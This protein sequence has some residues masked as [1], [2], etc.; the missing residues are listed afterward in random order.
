VELAIHGQQRRLHNVILPIRDGDEAFGILGVNVDV[1]EQKRAEEALRQSE[2]RYRALAESTHDII[3]ILDP[4]GTLLYANRAA[5]QCIG[6]PAGDL[7]GKRQADLFPPDLARA[8]IEQTKQVLATG[9]VLEYDGLFHFGPE[10]VWLRIHLLPIRDEAGQ[11]ASVMGVCHNITDRKRAEEALQ[12]AHDDLEVKIKERTAELTRANE[13]LQREVEERRRAEEALERSER[14]FRNYFEQGLIGMA[15]TSPMDKRWLMVNDRLCEIFGYP[16]E[17]LIQRSWVEMTHPDDLDE[18]LRLFDRL[19]AGEIEHFTF[20]KRYWKKDG[21]IVHTTIH[22]RVLRRDDGTIDHVVVLVE[23]I[24]A[25]KQAEEALRQ[26][27]AELRA[28][29]D[30]MEDG[31]LVAD[32]ETRRFVGA[33]AAICRM[34]G[35]SEPELLLLG[36]HDIHPAADISFVIAQFDALAEGRLAFSEEIPVSRKDGTIFYAVIS[37]SRVTHSGRRCVVGFFRDVTE[38]KQAQDAL[39]TSEAK[40]RQLIETTDTGYLILDRDGRV[41]DANAEYIR[42]SGHRHLSEILGRSV[43]EWTAPADAERNRNEVAKCVQTGSLR[44]LVVEYRH[45]DGKIIPVEVNATCIDAKDGVRILSL[46]RDVTERR[47]AQEALERERESLW[48]M[49]QASDHERQ[50]ISY[51]IHDGL[52]QYLAA[53]NMQLQVFDGLRH[54]NADEARKAYDAAT[55]LVR[56]AH[57]E[58]RRLINEVRPPVI[59]EIGLETAISHLV[60]EQRRH[61][62]PNIEFES[63]VQFDRLPSILEN[64]LY[65]IAQEALTNACKHSKSKKASVSMSQVGQNVRLEVRDQG[66]GFDPEKVEKGHFGLEG[67]RQRVR[68]LGGRLT[69]QS[70]PG[71]GTLVQVVVPVI[72][73]QSEG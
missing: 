30:G 55:Q 70:T 26:S 42:I 37:T 39:C 22:T 5:S 12:K 45:A 11:I 67:I 46:C 34:L 57:A 20:D 59:D 32:I 24:T 58:S 16:R 49:L 54:N 21:T 66:V 73:K 72:E 1:T 7:V 38:R 56:Q 17:E 48:R 51:E 8:H 23:D 18:N 10:A 6:I 60:H 40:Y 35:Y 31:L 14:Q 33:N 53:A 19:L 64:A 47:Q 44:Q 25:R 4:Q 50:T 27:H 65:R 61:G 52:A 2:G 68:L 69:I 41:M 62:G 13:L 28:I 9:E 36:V 63:D 3:Y 15:V 71:S 29:Y 43:V